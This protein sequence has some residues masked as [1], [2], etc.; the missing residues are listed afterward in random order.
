MFR[1]SLARS[2]IERWCRESRGGEWGDVGW[3]GF[4]EHLI[5][6]LKH[7]V[8]SEPTCPFQGRWEWQRGTSVLSEQP[9]SAKKK[10]TNLVFLCRWASWLWRERKAAYQGFLGESVCGGG[11][12]SKNSCLHS[13]NWVNQ[14]TH[15]WVEVVLISRRALPT[16]RGEQVRRD[17]EARRWCELTNA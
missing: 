2:Q 6:N 7:F 3:R 4:Q 16:F 10:C 15:K 17:Q 5:N 1:K 8:Q 9:L 13:Y 11:W 14:N 12:W